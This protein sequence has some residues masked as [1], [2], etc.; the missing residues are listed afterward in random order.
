MVG[1]LLGVVLFVLTGTATAAEKETTIGTV[2]DVILVP[3][4]VTMP[5]RIDTGAAK[6]SL[7]AQELSIENNMADFRLP[8]KYGGLRVRLPIREWRHVRTNEGLKRRP[9]VEIEV[10]IGPKRLRTLVALDN[11]TA[12]TYPFLVGR[13]IL[14]GNFVVDVKRKR[15][16]PPKCD[17]P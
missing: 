7:D 4:G 16:A 12:V 2:E 9:V 1:M 14:K 10:C 3:W 11:R 13:N 17:I 5:A 6:S 15:I 8:E